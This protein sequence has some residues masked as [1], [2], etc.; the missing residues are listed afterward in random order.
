MSVQAPPDL[1][2]DRRREFPAPAGPY[3]FVLRDPDEWAMGAEAWKVQ[4]LIAPSEDI[5]EQHSYLRYLN[6]RV[7][8]ASGA[9]MVPWTADGRSIAVIPTG[10]DSTHEPVVYDLGS[11]QRHM[12]GSRGWSLTVQ[13]APVGNRILVPR[14][15][16]FEILEG[17]ES[18]RSVDWPHPEREFHY[19]GWLASGHAWFAVGRRP[20]G[21]VN[22]IWF[23]D[24]DGELLT[25]ERLDPFDVEPFDRDKYRAISGSGYSLVTGVGERTIGT[26]LFHW[27]DS[28]NDPARNILLLAMTR[29]TGDPF[30]KEGEWLCGGEQ[31]WVSVRLDEG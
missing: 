27:A 12:P 28:R 24:P 6:N 26:Q 30:Q 17:G 21:D 2:W 15:D 25:E 13:G 11:E 5:T 8:V 3:T 10:R 14:I 16:G 19:S 23:F 31:R 1:G 7:G 29:P 18:V 9:D 4:L 20:S 22:W